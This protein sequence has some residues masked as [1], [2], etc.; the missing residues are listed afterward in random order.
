MS[1]IPGMSLVPSVLCG[2]LLGSATAISAPASGHGEKKEPSHRLIPV[3]ER[4]HGYSTFD[5]QV[6]GSRK[7]FDEFLERINQRDQPWN[8]RESFVDALKKADIDF[9]RESLV[10]VRFNE[11]SGSTEI[12]F[13]EP[14]IDG[15]KLVCPVGR[16]EAG[17]GLTVMAHY[18]RAVAVDKDSITAVELRIEGREP[19]TLPVK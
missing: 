4:E 17:I 8:D 1:F 2:V 18:A 12:T 14:R 11:A 5:S 15:S 10:L 16:T 3:P 9:D 7:A 6:I 13:G 19:R